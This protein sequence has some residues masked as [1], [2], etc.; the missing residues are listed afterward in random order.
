MTCNAGNIR[1]WRSRGACAHLD[2]EQLEEL[3]VDHPRDAFFPGNGQAVLASKAK[4]ICETCPV[5]DKCRGYALHH[6]GRDAGSQKGIW[7]GLTLN[8]RM[9][10]LSSPEH[11][12]RVKVCEGCNEEF[13]ASSGQQ[14]YCDKRC[15]YVS[16]QRRVKRE[17]VQDGHLPRFS[18]SE[19]HERNR[20]AA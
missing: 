14:K 16:I 18:W 7:G 10:I 8:E 2:D 6:M 19:Y 1:E 5:I 12:R 4:A 13:L 17:N 20:G 3:G 9:E 15:R 11:P